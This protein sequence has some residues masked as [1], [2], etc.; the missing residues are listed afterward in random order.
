MNRRRGILL[1]TAV[2][3]PLVL[4]GAAYAGY[5]HDRALPGTSVAGQSVAGLSRTQVAAAVQQRA[6][7]ATV[8]VR[9]GAGSQAGHLAEL[10]YT[11]DV[12]ATVDRTFAANA[13]WTSYLKALVSRHEVAPTLHVDQTVVAEVV[14]ALVT[15]SGQAGTDAAVTLSADGSSFQVTEA[16]PGRTVAPGDYRDAVSAA[17]HA[18]TSRA[19]TLPMVAAT[20]TVT[21]EAAQTVADAANR[22]LSHTVTVSDGT[23]THSPTPAEAAAWVSIPT[24]DGVPGTPTLAPAKVQAWVDQVADATSVPVTDGVRVVDAEGSVM[25]VTQRA[26]DGRSVSNA[27][28]VAAELTAAIG[29]GTDY[30]GTFAYETV[31]ATWSQQ[32]VAAGTLAYAAAPGVKWIDVNISKH[33][34]TA[35][36][37]TTVVRGPIAMVNGARATP[38]VVGTFHIYAKVRTQTMRGANADGTRYETPDVPWISYFYSGYA[39]HGA[40][41]RASFGYAGSHGCIN[42]P[43]P[44]A[45]WVYTWAPVGTTVVTHR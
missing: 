15:G 4:A 32:Q 34:M 23:T 36:E 39:L 40:P 13:S 45:K 29:A 10:G 21:T 3:V 12:D 37:G 19:V 41:W 16:Q 14:R 9:A 25:S 27:E 18:L 30:A 2:G 20:P 22:L 17:A 1:A 42:L 11:V 6:E 5:F 28:A 33:T 43:V 7:A 31:A 35:Y 8:T 38:T 24:Q 44:V 26:K